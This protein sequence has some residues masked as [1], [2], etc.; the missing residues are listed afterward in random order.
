MAKSMTCFCWAENRIELFHGA[1]G[2][3]GRHPAPRVC[4]AASRGPGRYGR[5]GVRR[6]D[7]GRSLSVKSLCRSGLAGAK[8]EREC[9]GHTDPVGVRVS[10]TGVVI[11]DE[12][13]ARDYR[14]SVRYLALVGESSTNLH[15]DVGCVRESPGRQL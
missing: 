12:F 10:L 11:G 8:R 4:P 14:I 1:S 5:R 6:G 3:G 2:A 7:P 9:Q 15:C 13:T